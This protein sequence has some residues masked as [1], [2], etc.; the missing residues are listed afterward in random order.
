M[1]TGSL[2]GLDGMKVPNIYFE[3]GALLIMFVTLGKFLEAKA[4]G[5]TSEAI[6]KLMDL[7][8]KTARV[9][10]SNGEIM[11]MPIETVTVN[12]VIIVRPGERIPVDGIITSGNSSIDESMLTGESMPVEKNTGDNVFT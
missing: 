8:P 7:A 9:K 12:D 3:V 5:K 2:I 10:H 11:D 1:Q 4:K 6:T